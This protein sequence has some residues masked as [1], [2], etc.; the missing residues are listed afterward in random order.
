MKMKN[1]INKTLT[2]LVATAL[3]SSCLKDDSTVLNP[4][5]G[6]NVIEFSNTTDIAV[7][8]SSIQ[9]MCIVMKLHQKKIF[10]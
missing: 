4:E 9:R 8:G 2:V 6:V 5:K 10:L 1:F 7:H 3:L